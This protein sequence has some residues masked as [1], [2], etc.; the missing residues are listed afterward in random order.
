MDIITLYYLVFLAF[1]LSKNHTGGVNKW[2]IFYL[3]PDFGNAGCRQGCR[4]VVKNS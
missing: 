2:L 1:G 4:V 3:F